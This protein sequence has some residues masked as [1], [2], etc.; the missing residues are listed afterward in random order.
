MTYEESA[1]LMMDSTFRGRVKVSCLK[2]ADSITNEANNVPAHGT[3]MRWAVNTM[4]QPDLVASNLT[5]PVTMD[6]AVQA[7]G[8]E[9]TDDA[10]QGSVEAVINKLM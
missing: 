5:P 7:A 6:G 10:L 3:R 9:I 4:Q 1:A 2:Y 8:A